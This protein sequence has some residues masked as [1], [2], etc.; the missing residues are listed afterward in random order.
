MFSNEKTNMKKSIILSSLIFF[1]QIMSISFIKAQT[2]FINEISI[3]N[4]SHTLDPNYDYNGWIELYN[5]SDNDIDL[6]K[7]YYSDEIGKTTKYTLS[8]TRI[9]LARSHAIIWLNDEVSNIEGLFLDTDPD[10][11]YLS[12][13]DENGVVLDAITYPLQY[14]NVSWGRESDGGNSFGYFIQST[15]GHSNNGSITASNVVAEP[16]FS[17][18]GGFYPAPVS[19]TITCKTEEAKIYYT[20]DG[21]YPTPLNHLYTGAPIQIDSSTPLRAKAFAEGFLEGRIATATYIINERVPDLP[22]FFLTTDTVN[23]YNDTIGMYCIGTNGVTTVYGLTPANYNRDWTRPGHV[24][25]LDKNKELQISQGCGLAIG[26]N[27]TRKYD[28]KSFMIKASKKYGNSR[29]DYQFFPNKSGR[30][31]KSIELRNGGQNYKSGAFQ[32]WFMQSQAGI[33]GLDYQSYQSSVIYMNGKYWGMLNTR[34]RHN[35]DYVYSNYG[36]D[37]T[38]IDVIDIYAKAYVK[39][40]NFLAYNRMKDFVIDNDLS[41]YT[42]FEKAKKLMD[43]DSFLK[44]LA[45]E[46]YTGNTD[47]PYNNQKL[48]CNHID[49]KFRWILQDLDEGFTKDS[50]NRLKDLMVSTTSSF[51]LKFILSLLKNN[52]FRD[53]YIDMQCLVAGSVFNVLKVEKRLDSVAAQLKDEWQYNT[54][55]WGY[56]PNG[57]LTT[58]NIFKE[59]NRIYHTTTYLNLQENFVLG[60][61]LHLIIKSNEESAQIKF[62]SLVIPSFPYDGMYFK[63]RKLTLKAP[64]YVNGKKFQC[65]SI[66]KNDIYSEKKELTL[67]LSLKDSLTSVTAVYDRSDSVRRGGLYINE[68]SASNAI[69]VDNL[70][71]YEDWIEIYNASDTSINLAGYYLSNDSKDLELFQFKNTDSLATNIVAGGYGIV[72]CSK[73]LLRGVMHSKF[74]L[75]KEGGSIFLS[76]KNAMGITEII[77]SLTYISHAVDASFGRYPDGDSAM[78]L[79][80]IPTFKATNSA[81]SY[82]TFIYNQKTSLVY[83]L[84]GV[85]PPTISNMLINNGEQ[86]TA[87]SVVSISFQTN[88]SA[89]YYRISES[90]DFLNASWK[91]IIEPE[92]QFQL[93]SDLGTKTIYLQLKNSLYQSDVITDTIEF[94]KKYYRIVVGLSGSSTKNTIETVNEE[95]LNNTA[96]GFKE[97]YP[98]LQLYDVWGNAAMKQAKKISQIS[99]AL[100]K[101][102][103]SDGVSRTSTKYACLFSGDLGVY[104]DRFYTR[105]YFFSPDSALAT[106]SRRVIAAFINVPNGNYDVRILASQTKQTSATELQTYRYQVNNSEIYTPESDIFY[107]N[108]NHFIE[109]RNITIEDSTLLVCAWKEPFTVKSGYFAPMNLIEISEV[110]T[111]AGSPLISERENLN[112]Y[113]GKG[114]I[115]VESEELT[116]FTIY[117]IDGM[118]VKQV[119]PESES[120]EIFVSPGVYIIRGKKAIAY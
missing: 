64:Q 85:T 79:F 111:I 9:L 8:E 73:D 116:P 24:E 97:T 61:P 70:Y 109:F 59:R 31:Y 103:I 39:C 12:I 101:Y 46:I 13:A 22:V 25:F 67:T 78:Y 11:G 50:V 92:I 72:W 45:I 6:S 28:Q 113:S 104:P 94:F 19:V 76:K 90:P 33:L 112:I 74:K 58:I 98:A 14:T 93:S 89:V 5:A 49:G 75:A 69:F 40:G 42:N 23:L 27:G 114:K 77:D 56:S 52:S 119:V 3:C 55:K 95:M 57:L 60:V 44:Y 91:P 86:K 82:N 10:G 37:D 108:Q 26:G 4:I 16:T 17:L 20:L 38:E 35:K 83:G 100:S 87:E 99:N 15:H 63:D 105:N 29:L 36:W 51:T 30:R 32:D 1:I 118:I 96:L 68:V 2:V 34:E 43:M 81:T 7:L 110:G 54:I 66:I 115:T 84:E 106:E 47:W 21:S 41:K 88:R 53:S 48:F 65:W 120:T 107:N 117:G 18:K 71:K 102:G 62:N 80:E